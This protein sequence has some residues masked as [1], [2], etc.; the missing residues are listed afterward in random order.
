M[1]NK[2]TGRPL[3]LGI[4]G[5]GLAVEKLHWPALR[6]LSDRF[7]VVAFSNRTR[8]NAEK[9][10]SYSGVSIDHYVAEYHDLLKRQDVDAVL[11][12]LPIPLNFP[13]TRAALEAGKHV[14]CEKPAGAD[15]VEGRAFVELA[16]RHPDRCIMIAENWFYRD[17][18]R[19]ARS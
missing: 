19:L 15:E 8:P 17:D 18:L 16:T 12:S 7:R 13:V 11:I 6:R 14:I 3:R 9:F 2:R 10:A 5:T 4:I 1:G